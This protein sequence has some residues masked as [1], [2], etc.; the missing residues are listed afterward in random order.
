M[1]GTQM[2]RV[3]IEAR[4]RSAWHYLQLP[5]VAKSALHD[6]RKGLPSVDPGP[7]AVIQANLAWLKRAQDSSR[8]R[9]GGVARDYS[10][11]HGWSTSYPETTGYIVPSVLACARRYG[12]SELRERARRMLD[13]LASI[14]FAEGSFQ[15]GRIDARPCVP[16]TFNTG[17][18]LLGLAAG[19]AEFGERYRDPMNR[20][21]SWLRD[22]LDADGCWRKFPTPF[23]SPGEK[24]YETHVSWGLLEAARITPTEGYAEAALRQVRWALTKQRPNGF[25]GSNDLTDPAAPLTHTIGYVLRG[26]IEAHRFSRDHA[27]LASACT[28]ADALARVLRDDGFLPGRLDEH[29]RPAVAWACLTGNAQIASCWFL[30]HRETGN[31]RYLAAGRRAIAF[32]RRTVQTT[33]AGEVRGGVKGSWPVDGDYGRF[34]FLNWAAKFCIDANLHEAEA[35]SRS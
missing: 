1:H 32:V 13:W 5:R 25:F 4:L 11:L 22:S 31:S 29:W 23:A 24:A 15:G 30:L 10:L 2:L 34:E 20:A 9:D 18:I 3:G 14:Q 21:A 35:W 8:S 33:G 19:A 28:T 12:N 16:V 26:V 27:F 17:Q 7:E 6:D